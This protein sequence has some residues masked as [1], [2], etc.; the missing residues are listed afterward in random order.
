MASDRVSRVSVKTCGHPLPPGM[1]SILWSLA[2][3]PG[4]ED[5]LTNVDMSNLLLYQLE[6]L[7]SVGRLGQWFTQEGRGG[8]WQRL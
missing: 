7:E 1:D 8:T 5:I 6:K 4:R 3:T 2:L